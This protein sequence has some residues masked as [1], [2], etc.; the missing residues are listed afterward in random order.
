MLAGEKRA[1]LPA[2]QRR[3]LVADDKETAVRRAQALIGA[4]VPEVGVVPQCA[5]AASAL[6]LVSGNADCFARGHQGFTGELFV[7][8]ARVAA[9]CNY[10]LGQRHSAKR[11]RLFVVGI[12]GGDDAFGIH[13]AIGGVPHLRDWAVGVAD[14]AKDVVGRFFPGTQVGLPGKF[15]ERLNAG[16][17]DGLSELG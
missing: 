13:V 14:A 6:N 12:G 9:A 11:F 8:L 1:S 15:V 17:V 2:R 7:Q 10:A 4:V 3:D 16:M 5:A